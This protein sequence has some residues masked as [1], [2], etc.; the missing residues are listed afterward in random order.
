MHLAD[1]FIPLS[2]SLLLKIQLIRYD[3]ARGGRSGSSL[4]SAVTYLLQFVDKFNNPISDEVKLIADKT[5]SIEQE[6]SFKCSFSLKSCSYNNQEP[7]YLVVRDEAELSPCWK[8]EF[9]ID[10]P[11]ALDGFDDFGF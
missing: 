4:C 11:F 1:I 10:I 6:R 3:S 8:K 5:S 2:K 7:Y 9:H